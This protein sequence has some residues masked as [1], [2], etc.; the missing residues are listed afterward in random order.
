MPNKLSTDELVTVREAARRRNVSRAAIYQAIREGRLTSVQVTGGG[1]VLSTREV[2]AY[3]PR[4][5]AHGQKLQMEKKQQTT[6][7]TRIEPGSAKGMIYAM[8]DD[9]N[10]PIEEFAEYR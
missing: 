8:G 7:K 2:D 6:A 1:V 3:T 10:A 4:A 9:F 5:R